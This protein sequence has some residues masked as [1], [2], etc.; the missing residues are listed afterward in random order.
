MARL[1]GFKREEVFVRYLYG[2]ALRMIL[3]AKTTTQWYELNQNPVQG[4]TNIDVFEDSM[5]NLSIDSD[6]I[7]NQLSY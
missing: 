6:F 7:T 2:I 5:L 4:T 1:Y 3:D